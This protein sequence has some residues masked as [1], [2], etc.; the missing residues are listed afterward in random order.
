MNWEKKS[1]EEKDSVAE[2]E[3]QG[4][5]EGKIELGSLEINNL[6]NRLTMLRMLLIPVVVGA[7]LLTEEKSL[8]GP[9]YQSY[10]GWVAGWI[11]V[12]ASI[13]DFFD[14]YIARKRNIVTVFGSFLDPIADK[15]LV[16]SSLVCLGAMGRIAI[17]LVIILILREMYMTSL[18]LLASNEGVAVPVGQLGKW[19][20]ATQMV[21]IPLLMAN[22]TWQGIPMPLLGDIA[23]YIASFL[24]MYSA[25]R[26]SFSLIKKL[27]ATRQEKRQ[28]K[29]ELKLQKK[30]AKAQKKEE[31]QKKKESKKEKKEDKSAKK[32]ESSTEEVKD[33]DSSK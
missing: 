10:L 15:F 26:Y 7:L 4:S 18:R 25:F 12:A 21:G 27:K 29:Q 33:S 5:D 22:E 16:V 8:I 19:K 2:Q 11:F 9:Y 32:D 14:G 20:T 28:E 23:I 24:S 17:V 1:M 30:L 31:K 13:T 6:P 3:S